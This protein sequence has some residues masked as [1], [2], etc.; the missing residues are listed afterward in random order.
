MSSNYEAAR[1]SKLKFKGEKKKR[2]RKR[3]GE[4]FENVFS[5]NL[6]FYIGHF[7]L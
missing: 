2:K 7:A 1:G 3:E 6:F 5:V 4:H